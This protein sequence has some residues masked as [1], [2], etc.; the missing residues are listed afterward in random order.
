MRSSLYSK[1]EASQLW[2]FLLLSQSTIMKDFIF[3]IILL[4]SAFA[5]NA[6]ATITETGWYRIAETSQTEADAD[7]TLTEGA[8]ELKFYIAFKYPITNN[9]NRTVH[10]RGTKFYQNSIFK[11]LRYVRETVNSPIHLEVYIVAKSSHNVSSSFST[12][13]SNQLTSVNF[14]SGSIPSGYEPVEL[15]IEGLEFV[16]NSFNPYVV[17]DLDNSGFNELQ[18]LTL[19]NDTLEISKGNFVL[20]PNGVKIPSFVTSKLSGT[21]ASTSNVTRQKEYFRSDVID[22]TGITASDSI[23]HVKTNIDTLSSLNGI[24][25][26]EVFSNINSFY[27]DFQFNTRQNSNYVDVTK[28]KNGYV[29]VTAYV[30]TDG[31]YCFELGMFT[32]NLNVSIL[33]ERDYIGEE[34]EIQELKISNTRY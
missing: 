15:L 16:E 4:L 30:S 9:V 22:A 6:Q 8:N 3:L 26:G 13:N 11:K 12:G 18:N 27:A 31:F 34:I 5:V 1:V 7:V 33:W 17:E 2:K 23:I 32:T 14:T 10:I 19:K 20:L 21:S 25:R 28:V 24:L 29:N